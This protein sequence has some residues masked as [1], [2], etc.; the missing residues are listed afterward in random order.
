MKRK[1]TAAVVAMIA[2]AACAQEQPQPAAEDHSQHQQSAASTST[3]H[4]AMMEEMQKGN[5]IS[6]EYDFKVTPDA[7]IKTGRTAPLTLEITEK[8][9]N[10]SVRDFTET[11]EKLM[12]LIIISSDMTDFQHIHPDVVGPGKLKVN[13]H[14]P[15]TGQYVVFGQF[16]REAGHESTVRQVLNVGDGNA[17]KAALVADA[18]KPKTVDGYT[19]RLTSYPQKANEMDM[20]TVAIEKDGKPVT[21]IE[22]YLG[23]GG[24]AVVIGQNTDSFLHVHPM[25]EAK[26]GTY[27]AP[28]QFHTLIP[29]PGIYK[30]WAQFQIDGKVRTTDFTFDVK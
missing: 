23:A 26:D 13:A 16:T 2:L 18:D 4:S 22:R 17:S 8:A 21:G 28:I 3:D 12:H 7:P 9:N 10:L 29:Q 24:H 11:H 1:V 6:T 25:T 20:I 30:L 15:K 19:Y 14:F 27:T 5:Q